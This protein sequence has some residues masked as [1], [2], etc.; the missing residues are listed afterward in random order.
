LTGWLADLG[1][2]RLGYAM[3]DQIEYCS[4]SF[5][6]WRCCDCECDCDCDIDCDCGNEESVGLFRCKC[7]AVMIGGVWGPKYVPDYFPS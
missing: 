2:A 5:G 6:F 7:V 3:L 4:L 1:W